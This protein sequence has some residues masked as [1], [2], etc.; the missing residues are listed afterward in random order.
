MDIKTRGL[1]LRETEYRD[2]DKI[3]TV[4]TETEGRLTVSARGV[5]RKN[6]KFTAAAQHLVFSEMDLF[7][8]AG[9]WYLR[10][11]RTVELF[12]GLRQDIVL[13]A[14]ACYFAELLE[15]VSDEDSPEPGILDLGLTALYILSKSDR[16]PDLIKAAF[17][18]RLMCLTGYAPDLDACPHCG[19]PAP[20]HPVFDLIGSA[21]SCRSCLTGNETWV[22]LAPGTL[23]ALRHIVF[24]P[25]N[26]IFSFTLGAQ[27]AAQLAEISEKY[28]QARLERGFRTL[29]YWKDIR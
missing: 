27:A 1:V 21:I 2:A 7:E 20:E 12:N 14:I 3:L 4:L 16:D 28:V 24:A 9:K 26:R 17:E 15:A 8:R 25:M 18:M 22:P 5:K 19:N 29:D 10:E 6:S 11:A 13:L 23:Q